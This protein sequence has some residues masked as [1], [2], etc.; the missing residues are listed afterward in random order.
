MIS[1]DT[2]DQYRVF[3]FFGMFGSGKTEL[4]INWALFLRKRFN[5]VALADIDTISPYFRSRDYKDEMETQGVRVIAPANPFIR[6]DLPIIVPAVG[7]YIQNPAFR[8]VIDVGGN[9]DGAT[10]LGSLHSF[11]EQAAYCS[12]FVINIQRPFSRTPS[13]IRQ[14]VE[15]LS[16]KA[17]IRVDYLINNTHLIGDTTSRLILDGERVVKEVCSEMGVSFGFSAYEKGQFP[18]DPLPYKGFP[19]QRYLTSNW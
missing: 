12:F 1:V 8:L 9:D 15:H 10:V 3:L 16:Q 19:I 13:E 7:G 4:S 11:I 18:E 5:Q 2:L 6:A 14:N 17:R